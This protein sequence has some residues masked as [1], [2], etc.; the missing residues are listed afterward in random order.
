MEPAPGHEP[1]S[2]VLL[3]PLRVSGL[4][5]A[6]RSFI[7]GLEDLR[8]LEGM[9]AFLLVLPSA[10]AQQGKGEQAQ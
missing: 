8:P 1:Q 3:P 5:A 2:S 4:V 7:P 10:S 9:D 6:L